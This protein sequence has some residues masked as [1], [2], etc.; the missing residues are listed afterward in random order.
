MQ[1][2]HEIPDIWTYLIDFHH[3]HLI[4]RSEVDLVLGINETGNTLDDL[5]SLEGVVVA[6]RGANG[7]L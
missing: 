2:C 5:I 1:N 7:E 6:N 3:Y 4:R